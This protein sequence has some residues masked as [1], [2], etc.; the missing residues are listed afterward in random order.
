M[1]QRPLIALAVLITRRPS[2]LQIANTVGAIAFGLFM[3]WTA[4][5]LLN[6]DPATPSQLAMSSLGVTSPPTIDAGSTFDVTIDGLTP[7]DSFD[8]VVRGPYGAQTTSQR[9]AASTVTIPVDAIGLGSGVILIDVI[10][11]NASGTTVIEVVPGAASTPLDLYL[12]PRTVVADGEDTSMIVAVPVDEFGNPV[13]SGSTVDHRII[14]ST[15]SVTQI[16]STTDGLLSFVRLPSSTV[17][18]RT[19]LSVEVGSATGP[20]RSF[21]NVAGLPESFSLEAGSPLDADDEWFADGATLHTIRTSVIADAFGNI[22]PDGTTVKLRADGPD[23]VLL[24]QAATI[25]GIA[26]FVVEAPKQPGSIVFSATAASG[27]GGP[28]TIES[29]PAVEDVPAVVDRDGEQIVVAVGPVLIQ[30][31]GFAPDGT[32]AIVTIG[33]ET[34]DVVLDEGSGVLIID[35]TSRFSESEIRVLSIEVLGIHAFASVGAIS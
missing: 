7:G 3:A 31:G 9:T 25:D 35:D 26:R 24:V 28:L 15:G 21:E 32:I 23:G 10:T 34:F 2:R 16:E 13:S 4:A 27:A 33:D 22:V 8:L 20:G 30:T 29:L 12:G 14:A 17:S 1:M 19:N 18:G 5:P 6:S 11:E